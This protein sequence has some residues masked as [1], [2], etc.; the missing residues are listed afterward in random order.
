[1]AAAVSDYRSAAVAGSKIKRGAGAIALEL[2][3][4]PDILAGLGAARGDGARPVLVGFAVET[5]DLEANA[6]RKLRAK[7]V[8]LVVANSAADGFGGTDN[9]ALLV[10]EGETEA[11]PRMSK[12]ALADRVLDRVAA[13]LA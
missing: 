3:P 13:L 9:V 2:V 11:L 7:R 12:E 1:M 5:D 6:R 8:D 4:N 10:S